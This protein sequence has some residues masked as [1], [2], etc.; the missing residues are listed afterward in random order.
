MSV[1]ATSGPR[2][3]INRGALKQ[4]LTA[5]ARIRVGYTSGS[6]VGHHVYCPSEKAPLT[7]LTSKSN[8]R[9]C[10]QRK[11]TG[12]RRSARA[13][14]AMVTGLRPHASAQKPRAIYPH[15]APTL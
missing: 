5:V 14:Q 2:K 1:P 9:P 7:A 12:V 13:N 4:K 8:D 10:V 3:A 6:Q 11:R 15:T